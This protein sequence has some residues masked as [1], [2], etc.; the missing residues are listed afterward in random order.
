MQIKDQLGIA[1]P[2]NFDAQ[3][4][5]RPELPP[6]K[7]CSCFSDVLQYC[8]E[9]SSGESDQ[10]PIVSFCCYGHLFD[11]FSRG[12]SGGGGR[13]GSCV[14][15]FYD[16]YST[17]STTT[18][19]TTAATTTTTTTTCAVYQ[20]FLWAQMLVSLEARRLG[21][22]LRNLGHAVPSRPGWECK[23]VP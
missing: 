17:S 2:I 7:D 10:G 19:A 4:S 5:A 22:Q 18:T 8:R 23:K 13:A 14:S 21:V 12:D 1:R 3:N 11:V 15:F 16:Y 6:M 20:V 9:C